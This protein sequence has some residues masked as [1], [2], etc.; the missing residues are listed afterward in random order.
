[1]PPVSRESLKQV[2]A[3]LI[4]NNGKV[5]ACQRTRHQSMPLKWEFPGGKVE[6]GEDAATALRRELEEELGILAEIGPLVTTIR[7]TYKG[8]AAF[9]LHFF[10]VQEFSGDIQNRIFREVR[11]TEK[12]ELP[13]LDFLE[14]DVALV[15]EIAAGKIL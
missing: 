15:K 2:V 8:D 1:M 7:H 14:A 11:W 6:P 5:L 13:A 10:L 12:Q 4:V 9:E 3:A